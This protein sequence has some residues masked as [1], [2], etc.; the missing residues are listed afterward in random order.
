L[1]GRRLSQL[2]LGAACYAL[3]LPPVDCWPLAWVTLVPLLLVTRQTRAR[4]AL[5]WGAV[6]GFLTAWT[7]TWWLV[8][9]I[10]AYFAASMLL[11]AA[12]TCTA[13]VLAV[14]STFGAF[15][16]L[17][18]VTGPSLGP[19]VRPFVVAALWVAC[20]FV[21][22]RLLGDPWGLLGYTQ[23]RVLPL[24]QI[25]AVTGVYGVSFVVGLGNAALAEAIA[26]S[27]SLARRGR[28]LTAPLATVAAVVVAGTFVL[29]GRTDGP[30]GTLPVAIVQTNV[31]PAFTWNRRYAERQLDQALRLTSSA[32]SAGP[33]L[34]V[35][36]E[37]ALSLYLDQEPLLVE[38]LRSLAREHDVDLVLGGPRYAHG[39]TYNSAY[40]LRA[41]DGSVQV[42]DKQRLVP[43]AEAPPFRPVQAAPDESPRSFTA[44]RVPG[45]LSGQA[46]LGLSIC[47][48]MLY[49]EVVHPAV[50]EGAAVLVNIAN[51][52]WLDG[53]HGV[54]SRQHFAMAVFRAVEARRYVV[55]AATTGI[56][57][58]ID[59]WGAV[60][61]ASDPGVAR[62]VSGTVEPR[63]DVTPYVRH[64]DWFA[65]TC[66][67]VLALLVLAHLLP[68]RPR[69]SV[70]VPAPTAS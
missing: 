41:Q 36:P 70:R 24:V 11:G 28:V 27:G 61:A 54:A 57:G 52:G 19:V 69:S 22:A 64:G 10:S 8:Q 2:A 18:A 6:A 55:R 68:V 25:A 44:G 5:A 21:R 4:A 51:D 26:A 56:S 32:L 63:H 39:H 9:A 7:V 48:E 3:A 58:V 43:V 59:P 33:R 31:P 47:H 40:L 12:A 62:V 42:Y 46:T 37:N 1:T 23:Y 35:W 50:A 60:V 65:A 45:L 15:A 67:L 34:V 20:E 16:L 53:G 29:H 17:V 66:F 13:Y 14:S 49:P 30:R 38:S